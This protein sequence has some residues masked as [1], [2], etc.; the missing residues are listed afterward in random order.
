M[1]LIEDL[2]AV[3]ATETQK[4]LERTTEQTGH[5]LKSIAANPLLKSLSDVLGTEWLMAILGEVDVEQAQAKVRRLK[6]KYPQE[7]PDQLAHRIVLEKAWEAGQIGLM[8][9][10][11][12]PIAAALL[13]ME[14]AATTKL[15][16]EMVYQIAAAYGLDL[17]E[18]ARRGEVVAIFGLSLGA[19]VLKG[20]VSLVEI[21]PG[22]GAVIGA[23]TNAIMFYALGYSARQFY[24]GKYKSFSDG[25]TTET[26]QQEREDYWRSAFVQSRIMD[27]VL[28]H[29]VLASYPDQRSWSEILRAIEEVSPSSVKVVATDLENPQPLDRLLEQLSPDFAQLLLGRCYRL[30]QLDGVIT[31]RERKVIEAIA[32][33]FAMDLSAFE[34]NLSTS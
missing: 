27:G 23:S 26:W 8:T 16:A 4:L 21:I 7:T 13:G 15:Q 29:M 24:E 22:V 17:H 14:L 3:T 25:A 11:I 10:V 6:R 18:P 28:V 33:N 9:N 30:A 34:M 1:A 19:G 12:P 31:P 20:G 5:T 2:I 32:D